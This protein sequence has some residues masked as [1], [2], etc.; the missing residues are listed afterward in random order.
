MRQRTLAGV[1]EIALKNRAFTAEKR[2]TISQT[3][4]GP[5]AVIRPAPALPIIWAGRECW[6]RPDEIRM[7]ATV[8]AIASCAASFAAAPSAET[9]DWHAFHR[10]G[11]LRGE[12]MAVGA[13]DD[14]RWTYYTDEAEPA[15]IEGGRR[16]SAIPSTSATAGQAARH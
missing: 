11:E 7:Q 1:R 15:D 5:P 10:G 8:L 12:A 6:K 13:A 9:N 2:A 4:D 16:S 14:V 3:C